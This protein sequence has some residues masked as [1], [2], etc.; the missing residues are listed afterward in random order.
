L[1]DGEGDD[2]SGADL[3]TVLW[4]AAAA[5]LALLIWREPD[6]LAP[7][8]LLCVELLV[9]AWLARVSAERAFPYLAT[10]LGLLLAIRVLVTDHALAY[11]AATSLVNRP[12]AVRGLAA[13]AMGIAGWMLLR[14][15][16]GPERRGLGGILSGAAG[17]TLLAALSLGWSSHF[18]HR[19]AE[20]SDAGDARQL[21]FKLQVGLSVLWTAYAAA[22]LVIGFV[23]KLDVVRYAALGLLGITVAK[24]FL[25]DLANLDA[26]YRV[27]S[28]LVLGV[29]LLAVGWGY[30]RWA[31]SAAG[32][33]K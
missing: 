20:A 8:T 12:L 1:N 25:V 22:S 11:G 7:A 18:R 23:R 14:S 24:V 9:L 29:V 32:T 13:A 2:P 27:L 16:G 31:Q 28:F 19:I 21:R 10:L 6:G 30:Q 3:R 15:R 17:L 33:E 4:S 26:V 5:V